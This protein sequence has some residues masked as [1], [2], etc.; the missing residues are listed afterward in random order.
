MIQRIISFVM[1]AGRMYGKGTDGILRLWI[2][3][4]EQYFYSRHAYE[5]IGGIHMI[6]IK[7]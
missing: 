6:G 2:E 4:E 7:P 3:P 5:T 1:I